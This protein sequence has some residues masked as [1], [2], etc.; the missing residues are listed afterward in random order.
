MGGT[1][2]IRVSNFTEDGRLLKPNG[3]EETIE[4][5]HIETDD[6]EG[7]EIAGFDYASHLLGDVIVCTCGDQIDPHQIALFTR[8]REHILIPARCCNKFRWFKGESF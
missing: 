8:K 3:D 1:F 4:G 2:T 7:Y 5:I 6:G